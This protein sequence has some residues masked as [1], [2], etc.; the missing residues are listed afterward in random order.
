M[1]ARYTTFLTLYE[2]MSYRRTAEA[3]HLTQPAVTKQM[4]SLE[5][6][7]GQK[8]FCYD[9]RKLVRTPAAEI[10]AGYARSLRHNE[11]LMLDALQTEKRR[12]LRIGATKTIGDFVIL[13]TIG[14]Y[15]QTTEGDLVLDVDNTE[16]LLSRLDHGQLDL[17][18][19]EGIF[20]KSRYA[21][22]LLS[23]ESFIG[24]C[25]KDHPLA[26]RTVSFE[27]LL[28]ETI[29]VRESGSGTRNI[30][31]SE[32]RQRGYSLSMFKRCI[33]LG[34]FHL[35]NRLI[36]EG[37]GISFAYKPVIANEPGIASFQVEGFAI[38][39]E[40]NIVTL[41]YASM[42]EAAEEFLRKLETMEV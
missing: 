37:L 3:L 32:L 42:T 36:A 7:L 26:G 31:E 15:L 10:F 19:I 25:P 1:D 22:R 41:P 12:A 2:Q 14:D 21:H 9:H 29:I 24:I 6:E 8:L 28:D 40:F 13:P 39:H 30:F 34:S 4:Q 20:D 5:R 16:A 33:E 11:C 38:A 17:A 23:H 27:R 35:I 18:L